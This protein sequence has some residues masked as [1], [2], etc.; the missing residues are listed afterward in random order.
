M[1]QASSVPHR[2]GLVRE[3][4]LL[5]TALVYY[6]LNITDI[7]MSVL[8]AHLRAWLYVKFIARQQRLYHGFPFITSQKT[9]QIHIIQ[10]LSKHNQG[11]QNH[12]EIGKP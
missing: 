2:K 5:C 11:E 8:A 6:S 7:I 1:P 9:K 4:T 12:P 3:I 10:H